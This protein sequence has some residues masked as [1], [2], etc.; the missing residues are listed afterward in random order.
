MSESLLDGSAETIAAAVRA[1]EVSARTVIEATLGS[2]GVS[3]DA[4]DVAARALRNSSS[5]SA[6]PARARRIPARNTCC[7]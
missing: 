5:G 4:E 6:S 7:R 2:L 1:G 3:V